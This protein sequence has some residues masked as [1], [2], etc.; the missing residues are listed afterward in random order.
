MARSEFAVVAHGYQPGREVYSNRLGQRLSV[1]LVAQAMTVDTRFG[2]Q[3][4]QFIEVEGERFRA[5]G[6]IFYQSPPELPFH[7]LAHL[8]DQQVQ[9][10]LKDKEGVGPY[11]GINDLIHSRVYRPHLV[12]SDSI[13]GELVQSPNLPE[14]LYFSSYLTLRAWMQKEHPDDFRQIVERVQQSPDQILGDTLHVILPLLEQQENGK[15]DVDLLMEIGR[16]AMAEDMGVIPDGLWLPETA[17]STPVLQSASEAGYRYI[18]LKDDQLIF[19]EGQAAQNP[20]WVKLPNGDE[21]AIVHFHTGL[22]GPMAFQK[23]FTDHAPTFYNHIRETQAA[24]G[25]TVTVVGGDQE[26]FG[27]HKRGKEHFL[28]FTTQRKNLEANGL[29]PLNIKS[30]LTTP[31]EKRQYVGVKE[32]S[33]WGCAHRLGRWTGDAGCNCN[34][35][36]QTLKGRRKEMYDKLMG[37]NGKINKLLDEKFGGWEGDFV[38]TFLLTKNLYYT[39]QNIEPMLEKI[40][41]NKEKRN[42]LKG[43]MDAFYGLTSCGWYFDGEDRIELQIPQSQ[44]EEIE[45]RF[46]EFTNQPTTLPQRSMVLAAA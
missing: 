25:T 35:E 6:G 30:K 38:R 23:E 11:T 39:G 20:T 22:S 45:W 19:P 1:D 14:G 46:P 29:V 43:K 3:Q 12:M 13:E 24:T 10:A 2:S 27:W 42:L 36:N 21:M 7:Q 15:R 31:T 34:G 41:P 28:V 44:I 9:E 32:F 8:S 26:T 37:Y 4:I 18:V 40:A 33:S 5:V 16:K 17:V